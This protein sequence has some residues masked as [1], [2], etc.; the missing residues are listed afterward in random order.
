[1]KIVLI[2]FNPFLMWVMSFIL[3]RETVTKKDLISFAFG[4]L[5]IIMLTDP[6]S[7]YKGID[8]LIGITLALLSAMSFNTGFIYLRAVGEEFHAWQVV[9]YSQIANLVF[10]PI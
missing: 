2:Q 6:F 5:G 9:F 4:M 1:S 10:S 8:D 3:I 7:H